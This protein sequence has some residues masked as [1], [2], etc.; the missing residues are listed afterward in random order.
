MGPLS[1]RG[2]LGKGSMTMAAAGLLASAPV[3]AV[4]ALLGAGEAPAL[5]D[6]TPNLAELGSAV[7]GPVVAHIR[8]LGAGEISV[9]AGE[10]EVVIRDAAVA[11][12]LL[13]AIK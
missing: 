4:T 10:R 6:E 2:F 11:A 13:R 12:R 3:G 1:R 5:E 8:D 9:F 7:D